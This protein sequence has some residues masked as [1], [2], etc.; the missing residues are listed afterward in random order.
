MYILPKNIDSID[1]VTLRNQIMH[2]SIT[3]SNMLVTK[4]VKVPRNYL[5]L[6]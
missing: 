2:T 3:L 6:M 4:A 1:R 5:P